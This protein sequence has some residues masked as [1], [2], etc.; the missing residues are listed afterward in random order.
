VSQRLNFNWHERV[1]HLRKKINSTQRNFKP[2]LW[3]LW[4]LIVKLFRPLLR[5]VLKD[6]GSCIDAVVA[7]VTEMEDLPSFDAGEVFNIRWIKAEK[8][9]SGWVSFIPERFSNSPGV[10]D[11]KILVKTFSREKVRTADLQIQPKEPVHSKGDSNCFFHIVK[12]VLKL[13]SRP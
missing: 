2:F 8:S 3:L 12:Q 6:G 1:W 4:R 5:R 9:I 13:K 10:G 11:W 7:A